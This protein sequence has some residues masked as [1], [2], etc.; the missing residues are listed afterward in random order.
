LKGFQRIFLKAGESR[1]L[2]FIL[3][4]EALS[5]VNEKGEWV[6]EPGELMISVGGG[7]PGV[8]R[9]TTSN[10]IQQKITIR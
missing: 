9:N 5:I 1:K 4:P 3:S 2:Q 10:T 6:Q 7:Q 8:N